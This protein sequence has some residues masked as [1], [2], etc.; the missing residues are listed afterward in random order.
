LKSGPGQFQ[1]IGLQRKR[2]IELPRLS[3]DA[4]GAQGG[5]PQALECFRVARRVLDEG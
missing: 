5:V 1:I 3:E 4:I 2:W